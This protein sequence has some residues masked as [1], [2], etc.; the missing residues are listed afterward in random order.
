MHIL[1]VEDNPM[2]IL[3]T[4]EALKDWKIEHRLHVVEDGEEALDF[5]FK[6]G[7][8]GEAARPDLILLD[9]NLPRR[10]GFEVLSEIKSSPELSTIT[11][12][13][14]TTSDAAGDRRKCHELG[15]ALY[16]TKP[17]DFHEYIQALNS[18][19]TFCSGFQ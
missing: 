5:L 14:V 11:L 1:L 4:R 13:V 8:H 9:L 2:D 3:M 6:R 17:L 19:E 7:P 12:V 10:S 15:A 18:V 16:I